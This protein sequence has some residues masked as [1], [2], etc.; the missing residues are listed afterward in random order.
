VHGTTALDVSVVDPAP[1]S[2]ADVQYV[3]NMNLAHTPVGLRLVQVEPKYEVHRAERGRPRLG[4]FH[5]AAWGD[6]RVQPVY[7]VSASLTVATVTIPRIRFVCRPD[8][9]AFEGTELVR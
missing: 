5:G 4:V 9:L 3:A 6:P 8:V 2:A 7:P 1:L